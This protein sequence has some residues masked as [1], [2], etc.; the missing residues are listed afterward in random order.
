MKVLVYTKQMAVVDASMPYYCW[1]P[2][3]EGIVKISAISTMIARQGYSTEEMIRNHLV[4][5]LGKSNEEIE[6][7]LSSEQNGMLVMTQGCN[8]PT[9]ERCK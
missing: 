9:C 3:G 8:D 7:L 4:S 1:W 5:L 6:V 2:G